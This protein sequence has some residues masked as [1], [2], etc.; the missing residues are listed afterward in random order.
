M[1][2]EDRLEEILPQVTNPTRYM[3]REVNSIVKN[4]DEVEVKVALA[5][6]DVYEV[7]MSHLGIKILYHLLN[8][9]DE[10]AAER[11][12]SPWEDM[13]NKM[14]E[15]DLP[16]F[17]LENKAPI[18]E[19]DILGFTL[20]YELS[21]SNLLNTLDLANLPLRSKDRT[22]K[23]PL[24][25]AGGP[26]A[27]N[28]EPLAPFIDLFLLGEAE[29]AIE[30]IVDKYIAWQNN[31]YSREELL[32]DLATLEGV[33]V[34]QFYEIDYDENHNVSKFEVQEGIK[35]E[36]KK[37]VVQ[38]LDEAFYPE[39][40]IVPYMDV[41]HDRVNLEIARGCTSGCRFCQAGMIYR[42]VRERSHERI[43]ELAEN[44]V[45]NTGYEEIS[46]TSLSSGDYTGVA[47][48]AMDLVDEYETD[49][50]S[51]AL[52]SMRVDSF[53]IDLAEELQKVRKTGLT[54]APEAGTQ[55]LRNVINK[56]IAEE[57]VI[58]AVT[59]AFEAGW[60]KVKLYF[61]I[62]LPTETEA[63]LQGIVDL[64]KKIANLGD[65]IR[66]N[67]DYKRRVSVNVSVSTFVPKPHTPFQWS[68]FNTLE[69][70]NDKIQYLKDNLRGKDLSLDWNE[71]QVSLLEAVFARGDRRTADL[72]E[73]AWQLGARFDGWREV[74][75][76]QLW[77]KAAQK[78]GFDLEEYA[79]RDWSLKARLPWDHLMLG[80]NKD[81]LKEEYDKALAAEKTNNCRYDNCS[82]CGV[83]E[84]L[85]ARMD[86]LRGLSNE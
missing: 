42:P 59:D 17:T 13:E 12:Y 82:N 41:V 15:E 34:P 77:Q 83:L 39:K 76:Y 40:F 19:F 63:D 6:P 18:S 1:E 25:I 50:I 58:S 44:L 75:D 37:R 22:A 43:K 38:N 64:A 67:S 60:R 7:G 79:C 57:D 3:G 11:V 36:V 5:F 55:R 56:G 45:S 68:Q 26:C 16:L 8:Q 29:A 53:S 86:L 24:V 32:K 46:L 74:F 85:E 9:R 66:L 4:L 61:M 49:K 80:V 48:L 31:N 35:E 62:G 73:Q 65:E 51:V 69:E 28:P 2:L 21:Y 54:F 84:Q 30:E 47:D 33:Y 81:Y 10:V 20:Q 23:H 70:I 71:P 72:L 52:P 27:S 14:K 78:T